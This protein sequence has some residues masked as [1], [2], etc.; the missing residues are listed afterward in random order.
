MGSET[1]PTIGKIE[2]DR[3]NPDQTTIHAT[4]STFLGKIE[5]RFG[6]IRGTSLKLVVDFHIP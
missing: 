2:L 6:S 4:G 5:R 1:E 3:R